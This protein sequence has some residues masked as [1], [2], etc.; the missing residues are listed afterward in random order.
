[1]TELQDQPQVSADDA[2][3]GAPDVS[4]GSHDGG[5]GLARSYEWACGQH[6]RARLFRAAVVAQLL[7][8]FFA[9]IVKSGDKLY[10]ND[11]F[12]HIKM[13]QLLWK[14]DATGKMRWLP[15]T[16]AGR[17]QVNHNYL[18]HWLLVPFTFGD[19]FSGAQWAA[20]CLATL[21]LLSLYLF[22]AANGSRWPILW[23]LLF[24]AVGNRPLIRLLM[25]RAIT[26]AVPCFLLLC[27][28]LIHR[29]RVGAAV[30]AFLCISAY[31]AGAFAIVLALT[32][33]VLAWWRDGKREWRMVLYTAAGLC[34]GLVL[35]PQFP[36][37]F[38]FVIFMLL[39]KLAG[40]GELPLEWRSG[41][42]WGTVVSFWPLYLAA[43]ATLVHAL[44][45]ARQLPFDV[46]FLG[47]LAALFFALNMKSLRVHEYFVPFA[48]AALGLYWR[49]AWPEFPSKR[50]VALVVVGALSVGLLGLAISRQRRV[51]QLI[52][53]E[54]G[55][56]ADVY[57]DLA[58]AVNQADPKRK[59]V[60][61]NADW[62][63]FS[64]LFFQDSG[65]RY[66]S[67][68]DPH[69]FSY[70]D[71]KRYALFRRIVYQRD[72]SLDLKQVLISKFRSTV[73]VLPPSVPL[74][75]YFKGKGLRLVYASPAGYVFSVLP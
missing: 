44:H 48:V 18:F 6:W 65:R 37:T 24:L 38:E 26:V 31:V 61:F 8:A 35:H 30:A 41:S 25:V 39:Y 42:T 3:P 34:L 7:F 40:A 70:G 72:E 46:W 66:V 9:S 23:V 12:Y 10:T 71:A 73:A 45:R 50:V 47:T 57:R 13:A 51:R 69:W 36:G 27:H 16:I 14:E 22:L 53:G 19:L 74:Y 1:M 58:Q 64:K 17:L 52:Q 59:S 2:R 63:A 21:S 33:F 32:F 56:K 28:C 43:G 4:G 55:R 20:I 29:R 68:L 5:T 54:S 11:G 75:I 49:D 62:G 67:G 60:V 15:F